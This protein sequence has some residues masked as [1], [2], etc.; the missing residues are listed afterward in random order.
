MELREELFIGSDIRRAA[1]DFA[2]LRI[3]VFY[4]FPYLYEGSTEYELDYIQTYAQS[5]NALLFGIYDGNKMVGATTCLPLS[6]E[7]DEVKAPFQK[8]GHNINEFLYFGESIIL[9]EYRGLGYGKRF[10]EV[11]EQQAIRLGKQKTCF[12]SVKRPFDHPLKPINYRDNSGLW[13]KVGYSENPDL[14]CTMSWLDRNEQEETTKTLI[15]W[16][17][18]L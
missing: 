12:C 3:S 6:E 14:T 13:T 5:P 16:T 11:R 9:P 15:F 8:Y 4:D 18:D 7:T 1:E 2:A 10:F 17:K